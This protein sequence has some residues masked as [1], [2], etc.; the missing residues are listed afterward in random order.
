MFVPST[1]CQWRYVPKDLPPRGT[2]FDYFD[3]WTWN[4][5]LDLIH[6]ALHVKCREA[7]GREASPTASVIDSQSLKSAEKGGLASIRKATTRGKKIKG[8]KRHILADTV[9]LLLHAGVHP[10]DIRDRDGGKLVLATL[11][12][13]IRFCASFSPMEATRDRSS[14][15][16]RENFAAPGHQDRQAIRSGAG[17]R[18]HSAPMSR[19]ADLCLARKM[20]EAGQGL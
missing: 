12:G 6:H 17:L 11:F 19:G 15:R 13:C 16:R 8:K 3:L 7:M 10:A 1:G 9:G 5:T 18:N 2:L 4:G 20:P 14:R